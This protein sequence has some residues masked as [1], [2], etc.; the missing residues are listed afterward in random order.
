ME[1]N[2]L[3]SQ[4]VD[5]GGAASP[6]SL[7]KNVYSLYHNQ[8]RRWFAITA[9]TSLLAALILVMDDQR[10]RAIFGGIPLRELPYHWKEMAEASVLRYGSFFISWFLGC[11]ALAATATAVNGLDADDNPSVWRSDGFQK[12]REHFGALLLTA[13]LTFCAFLAGM[14]AIEFVT[15]EAAKVV[16]WSRF[17]RFNLGA[18]LV[19][20]EI[21]AGIV[22]WLG[23][24]I[25]IL[26]RG[27]D[28]VWDALRKSVKA[29]N[30]YEGYLFLLVVESTVGSYVAWFAVQYGFQL[31]LPAAL[32]Y[33]AWY[34]WFIA[35]VAVLATAAVEPPMFIGFSLLAAIERAPLQLAANSQQEL[36]FSN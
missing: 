7:L 33:T 31:L 11:F 4:P 21:I 5:V 13:L 6:R 10:I 18:S 1:T 14:A 36:Y 25:P 8:F 35:F 30:G 16:G 26:L 2:F 15:F 24:S 32:R 3:S 28:S 22:S 27:N 29:S 19:G 17:A 12:A 20:Y 23:M 34:G 9:P